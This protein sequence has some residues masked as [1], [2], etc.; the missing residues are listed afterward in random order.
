MYDAIC[1]TKTW[2]HPYITAGVTDPEG[3]YHV[4]RCDRPIKNGGG[5]C[6]LINKRFHIFNFHV[7]PN[8]ED[9]CVDV[10]CR[11][12]RFILI[13]ICRPPGYNQESAVYATNLVNNVLK[14]Y[15][16]RLLQYLSPAI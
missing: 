2:L 11:S 8:I 7:M 6:V 16:I 13:A 15:S 5:V 10:D 3:Q 4:C 12:S 14:V 9:V 1:I